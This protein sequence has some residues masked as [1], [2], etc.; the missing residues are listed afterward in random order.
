MKYYSTRNKKLLSSGL[1][2]ILD[3]PAPD[4]GLYVP[5][6]FPQVD[7]SSWTG[8]SYQK[9]AAKI[10][11]LYFSELDYEECLEIAKKAYDIKF[12]SPLI[13]PLHFLTEKDSLLELWHGPTLAF[14]DMAL[15]ALPY[16]IE[17]AI[18][19][20]EIKD[21]IIILTATSGDT[22]KA[23]MEAFSGLK[24]IKVLVLYP[25]NKVSQIQKRQMLTN[26]DNNVRAMALDGDFDDCQR[27]VKETFANLDFQK[28]L[29]EKKIRTGSANSINI[30]RLIPQIVYYVSSY[31]TY[32]ERG[33]FKYGQELN[34]SVPTGNFGDILA[35]Y[36]AKKMGLPLAKLIVASNSNKVL[37]DFGRSGLYD[38]NRELITT[39][40]PSMDILISSNLERFL[41]H[42]TGSDDFIRELMNKRDKEGSFNYKNNNPD[43]LWGWADENESSKAIKEVYKQYAYLIDPHTAIAYSVAKKHDI[44]GPMM[45]LST[46]SP[47]KFPESILRA[48]NLK[49]SNEDLSDME[50]I[51]KI[52]QLTEMKPGPLVQLL[53][54]NP[55]E[56]VI[57]REKDLRKRLI[58]FMD[59]E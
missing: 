34:V 20:K 14:K 40:S 43:I 55:D 44:K 48:L 6:Y 45:V 33:V 7:F 24:N 9:I 56:E 53:E 21:K 23:A 5:E 11:S 3:G 1:Q 39:S 50:L 4:G 12:R 17:K 25:F 31:L 27:L 30:G 2:A 18:E 52:R 22:G 37:A 38:A 10:F 32:C 8:F 58:S 35:A 47:F 46:A 16:L 13:A 59:E 41:Y 29:E 19:K 57:I 26:K 51:G 28:E 36:Y 54:E 49:E 15:S 42:E